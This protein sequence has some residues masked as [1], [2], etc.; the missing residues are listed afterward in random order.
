[1]E[2][3]GRD[4]RTVLTVN[5]R[6]TLRRQRFHSAAGGSLTPVDRLV[7]AGQASFSVGVREMCCRVGVDSANFKRAA[8]SLKRTAQVDLSD[9]MLRTLVESEG[10]AAAKLQAEGE[11][12]IG[13]SAKDCVVEAAPPETQASATKASSP[14][15]ATGTA[16][17]SVSGTGAVP[18]GP[19]TFL[20]AGLDGV[21][22]PAIRQAEKQKRYE[23]A[24]QRR[25]K[26]PRRRGVRRRPL[27]RPRGGAA[28]RY[29]ELKVAG[30]YDQKQKHR[31]VRVTRRNCRH[32]GRVL[33]QVC[34][35]V[36]FESATLRSAVADGAEWIA[37][38]L[39]LVLPLGTTRILDFYH[40]AEH[41][42]AA[43]RIVFGETVE[44]DKDTPG[45]A[46]AAEV[47]HAVRHEGY[48]AFWE[49]LVAKRAGLR[50]RARRAAMDALMNYVAPR[51]QTMDYPRY[52]RAG[53]E[54]GSGP[55]EAMC[56]VLTRRLKGA[57]MRWNPEN[58]EAMAALEALTQSNLWNVYWEQVLAN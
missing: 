5:G 57:G 36:L 49:K 52:E 28:D 24:R 56:K 48:E 58:A 23:A 34:D 37:V 38:Q 40:L 25:R 17:A 16:T 46:W 30:V 29:K 50:G 51:R 27:R 6:I 19:V 21:M 44:T 12:K 10:Q 31:L 35:D 14:A 18:A 33:R 8:A 42:N 53:L 22:A 45:K 41:V 20:C 4:V 7:D 47:L 39:E 2:K 3:K 26:L 54:I 32:A 13:W 1:M 11:L 43:R 55:T 15:D 9:E